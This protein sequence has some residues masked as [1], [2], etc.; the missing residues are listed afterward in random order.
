MSDKIKDVL[1]EAAKKL[2]SKK[3]L[4]ITSD[5]LNLDNI[6][7]EPIKTKKQS[8]EAKNVFSLLSNTAKKI[9]ERRAVLSG[10]LR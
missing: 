7:P 5:T 3:T 4:D 8:K 2:K 6:I 10:I 1:S 9:Q